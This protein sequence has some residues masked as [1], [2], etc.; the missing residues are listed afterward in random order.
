MSAGGKRCHQP[1]LRS[2]WPNH[3]RARTGPAARAAAALDGVLHGRA[4]RQPL[5][6]GQRN[7]AHV[8]AIELCQDFRSDPAIGP[9]TS[10]PPPRTEATARRFVVIGSP[11][12]IHGYRRPHNSWI[13]TGGAQRRTFSESPVPTLVCCGVCA[14]I[15]FIACSGHECC[16][17][18]YRLAELSEQH[19]ACPVEGKIKS[20]SR[21]A[22]SR[23]A[24]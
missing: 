18:M 14:H 22:V 12:V 10:T 3:P 2:S 8:L 19:S 24:S 15:C 11:F 21:A 16:P 9:G 6:G 7:A 13:E 17:Q 23:G 5:C 4:S 20:G 1:S